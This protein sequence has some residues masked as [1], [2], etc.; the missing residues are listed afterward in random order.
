MHAHR[1]TQTGHVSIHR[2]VLATYVAAQQPQVPRHCCKH[3]S[4][5]VVAIGYGLKPTRLAALFVSLL[6]TLTLKHSCGQPSGGGGGGGSGGDGG[7]DA[8]VGMGG[9]G[10]RSGDGGGAGGGAQVRAR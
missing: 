6:G 10:G 5:L 9:A 4:P 2:T 3:M 7:G 1:Q 8:G